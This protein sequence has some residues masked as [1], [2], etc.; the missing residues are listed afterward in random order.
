RDDLYQYCQKE[1]RTVLEIPV[2]AYILIYLPPAL[3]LL[4]LKS[5][6]RLSPPRPPRE[7]SM[8]RTSLACP[9]CHALHQ[10]REQ[11]PASDVDLEE[12]VVWSQRWSTAVVMAQAQE[13]DG[14]DTPPMN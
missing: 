11:N 8:T 12:L 13:A 6:T 5:P 10:S 14:E 2:F 7:S 3:L 1:N 9:I 4:S